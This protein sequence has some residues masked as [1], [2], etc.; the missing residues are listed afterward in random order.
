MTTCERFDGWLDAGMPAADDVA[1]RAHAA[2]CARCARALDVEAA[3]EGLLAAPGAPAPPA[4]T[5]AVMRTIAHERAERI[6]A[7]RAAREL[8]PMWVRVAAEP[9]VAA[10]VVI[11]ALVVWQGPRVWAWAASLGLAIA[12]DAT[13]WTIALA[14]PDDRWLY[15]LYLWLGAGMTWGALAFVRAMGR[16]VLRRR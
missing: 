10:A 14:P 2:G 1:M 9:R 11:A 8:L 16:P 13:T 15:G 7:A 3:L 5:D 4:F 6:A 12:R